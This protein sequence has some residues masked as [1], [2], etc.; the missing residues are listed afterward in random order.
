MMGTTQER[1]ES[2]GKALW[3]SKIKR[4]SLITQSTV[5]F[6]KI[7]DFCEVCFPHL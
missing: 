2:F 1:M 5:F 4:S 6:G 7:L 3:H